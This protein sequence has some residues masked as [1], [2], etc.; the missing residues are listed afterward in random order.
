MFLCRL[1]VNVGQ[2]LIPSYTKFWFALAKLVAGHLY[3][4]LCS[5]HM[6][7]SPNDLPWDWWVCH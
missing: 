2:V 5:E 4:R 3:A 6:C 7:P 1:T